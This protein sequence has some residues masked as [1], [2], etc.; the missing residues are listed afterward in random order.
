[1]RGLSLHIKYNYYIDYADIPDS[2]YAIQVDISCCQGMPKTYFPGVQRGLRKNPRPPLPVC[3]PCPLPARHVD[4]T[5]NREEN[6]DAD[7]DQSDLLLDLQIAR[8]I[9]GQKPTVTLPAQ[10][11]YVGSI[12]SFSPINTL[13]SG[14]MLNEGTEKTEAEAYLPRTHDDKGREYADEYTPFPR[15]ALPHI[16]ISPPPTS[17][18]PNRSPVVERYNALAGR[19]VRPPAYMITLGNHLSLSIR[20]PVS[21]ISRTYVIIIILPTTSKEPPRLLQ[22]HQHGTVIEDVFICAAASFPPERG[23]DR[24]AYTKPDANDMIEGGGGVPSVDLP[25]KQV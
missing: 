20:F 13:Y 8:W 16:Q 25:L 21:H 23:T 17:T 4:V 12:V 22:E 7:F 15:L 9:G 5:F 11:V 18:K 1:M 19:K 2:P 14:Y 6:P 3:S 24:P 10:K